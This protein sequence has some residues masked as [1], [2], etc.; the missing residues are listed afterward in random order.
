MTPHVANV[1]R[2][3]NFKRGFTTIHGTLSINS[4]EIREWSS[5]YFVIQNELEKLEMALYFNFSETDSDSSSTHASL[6]P[7]ATT[8]Q[9]G[10]YAPSTQVL[11][12]VLLAVHL[13]ANRKLWM[14]EAHHFLQWVNDRGLLPVIKTVVQAKTHAGIAF[15]NF[16]LEC[17]ILMD[18]AQS[19]EILL[20]ACLDNSGKQVPGSLPP[21]TVWE[22]A[23]KDR[24]WA[25]IQLLSR[26]GY[27]LHKLKDG[28]AL[29]RI[30]VQEKDLEVVTR[31]IAASSDINGPRYP[32]PLQVAV[33]SG[34]VEMVDLLLQGGA[35]PNAPFDHDRKD[36][37]SLSFE[38][39]LRKHDDPHHLCLTTLQLAIEAQDV[40][41]TRLLLNHDANSNL[42]GCCLWDDAPGSTCPQQTRP[43]QSAV[44]MNNYSLAALLLD[45]GTEARFESIE[46]S[47]NL[48]YAAIE[49]E[50]MLKVFIRR[51]PDIDT[52]SKSVLGSLKTHT[53]LIRALM[54]S[55]EKAN[56]ILAQACRS[57]NADLIKFVFEVA[58]EKDLDLDYINPGGKT[59]LGV[60]ADCGNLQA[61]QTLLNLGADPNAPNKAWMRYDHKLIPKLGSRVEL[62]AISEQA[63][64]C[65]TCV[66]TLLLVA[67]SELAESVQIA[68]LLVSAGAVVEPPRSPSPLV[69]ACLEGNV[70]MVQLLLSVGADPNAARS[71]YDGEELPTAFEA[72][73]LSQSWLIIH[74]LVQSG[75]HGNLD[76]TSIWT[77]LALKQAIRDWDITLTETIMSYG[78]RVNFPLRDIQRGIDEGLFAHLMRDWREKQHGSYVHSHSEI[79]LKLVALLI[80]GGGDM[81]PM[82]AHAIKE[83]YLHGIDA[84][85]DHIAVPLVEML[86]DARADVNYLPDEG[87][88]GTPL[89]EATR[90]ASVEVV[91]L[92]LSKNADVNALPADV[93]GKTA[94]QAATSG[95][96][97]ELIQLVLSEGANVNAPPAPCFGRTALQ[98]A[99]EEN[100]I[101]AVRLFLSL[102]A[103]INAAACEKFGATALQFA[104]MNGNLAI[105]VLLLES[106]ADINA[107]A[108]KAHGRTALNGAAEQGR[109]DMVA[110]LLENDDT[111]DPAAMKAKCEQAAAI[112]EEKNHFPVA[113]MLREWDVGS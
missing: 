55:S 13:A 53:D 81:E 17:A 89:Q 35:L 8:S 98:V 51:S 68:Q 59:P 66:S 104:A 21:S 87:V 102:G 112:A 48:L 7:Q 85:T 20:P 76:P 1:I 2:K 32:T 67:R 27:P 34:S 63:A 37:L 74:N 64:E 101:E 28:A 11:S 33:I 99:A 62:N 46:G 113:Q 30:Y 69:F 73:M 75:V 57:T 103:D 106:G 4:H 3:F 107:P 58:V 72:A 94:L 61:V 12:F 45:A 77:Q 38:T 91:Q 71:E 80:K 19:V 23:L 70:E 25:I 100:N 22:M 29:L 16:L 15:L 26:K 49:D 54:D 24:R 18:D 82:L 96:K 79:L 52:H 93:V 41:K 110:L 36:W 95:G 86:L 56:E 47:I 44:Q 84:T 92:L 43:L 97:M 5:S 10:V 111:A 90:R 9:L 65:V 88:G 50:D 39:M 83:I 14:G 31:I 40:V 108:G 42:V 105:A 78:A 60:A 109:L 6:L